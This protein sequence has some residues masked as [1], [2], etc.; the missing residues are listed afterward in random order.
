MLILAV[1]FIVGLVLMYQWAQE[2]T[3][4]GCLAVI[5]V[6]LFVLLLVVSILL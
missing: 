6:G 5:I 4:C 1:I 3:G 2:K